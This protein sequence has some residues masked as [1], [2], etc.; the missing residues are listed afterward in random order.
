MPRGC[1]GIEGRAVIW[2]YVQN[3]IVVALQVGGV[4]SGIML[5]AW[6]CWGGEA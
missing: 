2:V 4:A 1:E 3:A 5:L 6:L